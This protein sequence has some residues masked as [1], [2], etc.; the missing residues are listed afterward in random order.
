MADFAR[1]GKRGTIVLPAKVRRKYGF[2]EGQMVVA[3]ESPYGV[4][5]RPAAVIPVE[6]YTPERKAEFL[7]SNAV[8]AADYRRA[9]SAVR[10]MGLDPKRI[11]HHKPRRR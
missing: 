6:V 3:E 7:L 4:L 9:T 1:I 11:K 5:L 2:E 8:D 10:Q